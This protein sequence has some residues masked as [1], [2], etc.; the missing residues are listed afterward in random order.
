M[1]AVSLNQFMGC[2][3]E[4]PSCTSGDASCRVVGFVSGMADAKLE[5]VQCSTECRLKDNLFFAKTV[6]MSY[7]LLFLMI[8]SMQM[9]LK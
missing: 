9:L 2:Y 3:N 6:C 4:N 1:R 8:R 7:E 5:L